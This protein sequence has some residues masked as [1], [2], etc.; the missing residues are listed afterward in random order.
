MVS[1]HRINRFNRLLPGIALLGALA[2]AACSSTPNTTTWYPAGSHSA[3]PDAGTESDATTAA[4]LTSPSDGDTDVP[5]SVELT[6]AARGATNI[7]LV[8]TDDDNGATVDGGLRAD[9]SSWVPQQA[10]KYDTSFTVRLTSLTKG[11]QTLTRS[12]SFTTMSKP[13]DTI[14]LTSQMGD[15]EVYGVGEPIVLNFDRSI[16]DDERAAVQKRLFVQTTPPQEGEWNWFAD[17]EVHY[18]PKTYWQVGTQIHLRALFGGLPLGDDQYGAADVTVDASIVEH[19]V[20]LTVDDA[21]KSVTV[22]QDGTVLKKMPASLGKKDTP[23]SSGN[24]VVMTKNAAEL[25]DSTNDGI[26]F[27]SPGY[28]K[29]TINDALRL[30]WGGQYIHSAPWSTADQGTYDVSHGCTNLSPENADWL[31]SV[32]HVG[33]PVTVQNTGA[34]LD[35]GD[36]WTDWNRP[37]D[38]YVQ[39]SAI[40]Y[41]AP[42]TN[43]LASATHSASGSPSTA[44]RVR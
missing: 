18:R 24:M 36:G 29:E 42:D 11:G 9:G 16:P 31:F 32:V 41:T 43:G 2:L 7:R 38:Q 28:Y 13:D 40:P 30:T 12:T 8:L 35:W 37:W 1:Y 3:G 14:H 10:L 26:P 6:F 34:P 20:R 21:T 22:R 4:V 17:D 23:S 27:G 44:S 19:D 15:G 5:A 25:F 33:D 39:D